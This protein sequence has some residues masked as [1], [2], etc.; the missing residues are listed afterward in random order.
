MG[1]R[2][3]AAAHVLSLTTAEAKS[4]ALLHAA[5]CLRGHAPA[6]LTANE[7]DIAE[8][9]QKEHRTAHDR[10]ADT[11]RARDRGNGGRA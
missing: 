6:I 2:A 4:A 7:C 11:G 10:P 5:A 9:Q 3:R 8:A 1:Q